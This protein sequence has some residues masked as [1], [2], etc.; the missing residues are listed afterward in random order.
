MPFFN[1]EE[2][3]IVRKV[4]PKIN[5][6]DYWI[7]KTE[8][9]LYKELFD[10]G[11]TF[12]KI[13]QQ[14]IHSKQEKKNKNC[15][16]KSSFLIGNRLVQK[17]TKEFHNKNV[18]FIKYQGN[19]V[20]Y[21]LN[22]TKA[23]YCKISNRNDKRNAY[24]FFFNIVFPDPTE[25][26][27]FMFVKIWVFTSQRYSFYLK[28]DGAKLIL[29]GEV[30][31]YLSPDLYNINKSFLKNINEVDVAID[32]NMLSYIRAQL[33]DSTY[34]IS[35]IYGFRARKGYHSLNVKFKDFVLPDFEIEAKL[36]DQSLP[37]SL[38]KTLSLDKLETEIVV[39]GAIKTTWT[40]RLF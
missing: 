6:F 7:L 20:P 33:R 19:F 30:D 24:E 35:K 2:I 9:S 36:K 26:K 32:S 18:I 34:T 10:Y 31:V 23:Y 40:I 28:K 13:I 25:V 37:D 38:K 16:L 14:D 29:M 3:F 1:R 17:Q 12:K 39:P 11:I 15:I 4:L 22:I 21:K 5:S 8:N 27:N